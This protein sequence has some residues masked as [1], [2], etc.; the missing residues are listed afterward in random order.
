MGFSKISLHLALG[1][2][3]EDADFRTSEVAPGSNAVN[4]QPM[5]VTFFPTYFVTSCLIKDSSQA[6]ATR[7]ISEVMGVYLMSTRQGS[8][9]LIN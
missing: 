5:A 3:V 1:I 6:N 8:H 4:P 9:T 7:R 2:T